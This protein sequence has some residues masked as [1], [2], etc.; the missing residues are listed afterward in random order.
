VDQ[1]STDPIRRPKVHSSGLK[2][3]TGEAVYCDDIPKHENELYLALVLS[4][5]AHAKL[6]SIDPSEALKQ[7]GVHAFFSAKDL[8][9][10]QNMIGPIFHDEELFIR[11]TV[12]SQGQLL[13][14]IAADTQLIAQ[15]AA[16][17]VK[18]VYEPISP[19]IVTI[20][21]AIKHKSFFPG[22]PKS[23]K[24]GDADKAFSEADHIVTGEVRVGGQEHFYLETNVCVAIPKDTDELELFCST[25]H[26]SEVLKLTAHAL[27]IPINRVVC[28][29]KRLGGGFGGK[30]SRGML[31]ALPVAL[32][33]YRLGRPV[34]MMLDRDEDMLITG[35]RHPF[36]FRYKTAF[37]KDGTITGCKL[38]AFNNAGYS[39]DLSSSV[40]DRAIFHFQNTYNIPNVDIE[41]TVLKTNLPSNTAFRGFGGPQGMMVG[42]SIVRDIARVL[43]KDFLEIMATNM[44]KDGDLTHY[45]QKILGCNVMRCFKEVQQSSEIERRRQEIEKFN[46]LNRWKKRG[47]S[48]VNTMFGI[49]FTALHLNQAG[50]LVHIYV[51]GSVLISHGGVEMGQGL[52]IKVMQVA[53]TTLKIPIER[54][55]IQET[56]TDKVP[57]TSATAASAGSD[58]NGQAVLNACNI[59][60]DRLAPYREQSPADGWD[61]WINKAYF[62]RVSLSAMGFHATP[63]IGYNPATNTGHPFS[64]HTY[65]SAVSEIEID[66]LTGDHQVIRTDIVMDLG[67]S[68]NPAIDIGQIEGG[69]MQG[70]GLFTLE[71]LIYS[72]EGTLYSRGPGMYKLPG[73]ADIPAEFNVSLLTGAPNPRAVYSSKAVGE[74]PLFLA[75]SVFFAIK[76]AISSARKEQKIEPDFWLESPATSARIR[77]AC[78]DGITKK[79]RVLT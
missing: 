66:C 65:G 23:L 6:I 8:T 77:M 45:N 31:I 47:I 5:K 26:P 14:A 68:L 72:P 63:G 19:V 15:R 50:A 24:N 55:H 57:N 44:Y 17:M 35:T 60:I 29:T 30:E 75:S 79:V 20:E 22:S 62:D 21:D 39:L 9:P 25:Q 49:A 2:Q 52:H 32:A 42:E 43:G 28:R 58:L 36:L 70:Y 51:D 18:V 3:A 48:L 73:F 69:F 71:E 76:E 78:Q 56:S 37:K 1:P 16:R 59:L 4:S 7:P 13:G 54:I 74:P 53:A 33:A 64:Y 61:K 11:D 67:S 10:H 46:S 27:G 38:E 12:T 40:L 34:R 41:A